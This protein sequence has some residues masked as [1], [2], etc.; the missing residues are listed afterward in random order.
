MI[1]YTKYIDQ[2]NKETDRQKHQ[3]IDKYIIELL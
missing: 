3:Q 2:I 1:N